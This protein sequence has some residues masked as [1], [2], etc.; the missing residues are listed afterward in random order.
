MA[1]ISTFQFKVD[2]KG[3]V[4]V[5]AE[6]RPAL[7]KP[8]F[9]GVIAFPSPHGA[10]I[11]GVTAEWLE[12]IMA[13]RD[14]LDVFGNGTA[15]LALNA[16]ADMVRLP[17]DGEGRVLLSKP[18]TDYAGIADSATF[19]GRMAFFEIWNPEAFAAHHGPVSAA[20]RRAITEGGG[21]GRS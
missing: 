21:N 4:S 14:P 7:T 5:P 20:A 11:R 19:V 3:R 1:F 15:D 16:A 12:R 17:F 13:T 2:R 8:D 18:L 9:A 6:F 10:A